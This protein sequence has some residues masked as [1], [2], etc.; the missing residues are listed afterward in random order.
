MKPLK[1]FTF[2]AAWC[3]FAAIAPRLFSPEMTAIAAC[4]GMIITL[5]V[6]ALTGGVLKPDPLSLNLTGRRPYWEMR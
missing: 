4:V 6:L 3:V 5:I 2:I 1:A